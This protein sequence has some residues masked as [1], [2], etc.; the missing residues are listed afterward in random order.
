VRASAVTVIEPVVDSEDAPAV[1]D[2][3]TSCYTYHLETYE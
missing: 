1:T 2:E 3:L